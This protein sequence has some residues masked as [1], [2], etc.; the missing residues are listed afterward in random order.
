MLELQETNRRANREF[1]VR[2]YSGK[3]VFFQGDQDAFRDPHA[4]WDQAALGGVEVVPVKGKEISVLLEPNVAG[5]AEELRTRLAA[6]RRE[7]GQ[8]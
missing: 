8:A 5:L 1:R 2:P 4:F 6:A 3:V 7:A